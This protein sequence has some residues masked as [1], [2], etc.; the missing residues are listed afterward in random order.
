[1]SGETEK[2]VSAWT[3]DTLLGLVNEIDRRTL[4]SLQ[5]LRDAIDAADKRYEQRFIAQ[6]GAVQSALIAQE[7]AVNAALIAADRAVSKAELA[8]ERRN[9]ATNEF[10]GQLSDQAATLMPRRETEQLIS[11]LADRQR[12]EVDAINDKVNIL[13]RR[14]DQAEGSVAGVATTRRDIRATSAQTWA[15]VGTIIFGL[16]FIVS[17]VALILYHR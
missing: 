12:V 13:Q 6:E 10:R 16:G 14:L 7:K 8:Q 2:A 17:L 4:V 11:S 15:I 5:A 1:L 3:T 9:E